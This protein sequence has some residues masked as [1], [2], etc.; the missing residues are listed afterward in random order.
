MTRS[1][2]DGRTLVDLVAD[3]VVDAE[4]GAL[5]WLLVQDGVPL[6]VAAP[7]DLAAPEAVAAALL[8]APPDHPW[9]IVDADRE[10]P[11]AERLGAMLRGGVTPALVLRARSLAEVLARLTAAPRGLPDD[12]ARRLGVVLVLDGAP[13]PHVVAAHY[14]RP[15]ERDA[16][17]HLQRRPPAVLAT[18]DPGADTWEHYAWGITPELA[19]RVDRSQADLEHRQASRSD[20]LGRLAA[21]P[22][23]APGTD[24]AALDD[25]LA[26]EP[27]REPAPPHEPAHPSGVRSPLT[28]PHA[29]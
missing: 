14:L 9:A 6:V 22:G 7:T 28:D 12:A 17:G 4:L 13:R 8:G 11:T 21:R 10:P 16:Q 27:S 5:L 2:P 24:R 20:A 25:A 23:R 26:A 18:R 3:G 1:T 19:D 29:H 15:T